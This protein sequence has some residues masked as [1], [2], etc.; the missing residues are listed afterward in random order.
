M[1]E[2]KVT[3][4]AERMDGKRAADLVAKKVGGL[5]VSKVASTV[6]MKERKR[7]SWLADLL[8][9]VRDASVD[10]KSVV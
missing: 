7:A 9:A 3:L 2:R 6:E 1:A 4:K 8:A 5:D 10:T